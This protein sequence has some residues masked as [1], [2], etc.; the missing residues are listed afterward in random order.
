MLR[1]IFFQ[2]M[3]TTIALTPVAN[4]RGPER[5]F[6]MEGIADSF[7]TQSMLVNPAGLSLDRRTWLDYFRV[8]EHDTLHGN[9]LLFKTKG[10]GI[11]F[12]DYETGHIWTVAIG[13]SLIRSLNIDAGVNYQRLSPTDRS[14]FNLWNAGMLWRALPYASFGATVYNFNA[15]NSSGYRPEWRSGAALRTKNGRFTLSSDAVYRSEQDDLVF[16]QQARIY[17]TPAVSVQGGIGHDGLWQAGLQFDLGAYRA[18]V[19]Q[20]RDESDDDLRTIH[21]GF[22]SDLIQG[23][24]PGYG[25]QV[26]HLLIDGPIVAATRGS[27][28][29]L[30]PAKIS[31]L[32]LIDQIDQAAVD[33]VVD[34]LLLDIRFPAIDLGSVEELGQALDRFKATGKPVIA[35]IESTSLS[36]YLLAAQADHL[37]L[38]PEGTVDIAGL[39]AEILFVKGLLDKI[40]IELDLVRH[41]DYKTAME[42]Y[43]RRTL[44]PAME[45]SLQA[46]L[47]DLYARIV[48]LISTGRGISPDQVK[49]LIDGGLYHADDAL[50]QHLID[51]LVDSAQLDAY[52]EKT[53]FKKNVYLD[54][55][56]RDRNPFL[57]R[58]RVAWVTIQG[59]I[60]DGAGT[61]VVPKDVAA[62]PPIALLIRRAA[63]DPKIRAI[64]IYLNTP[65]GS[66]TASETI[67]QAIVAARRKKPV[68][69]LMGTVA[70]SG[71][72]WIASSTERIIAYPSTLTG[73]IGVF[74]VHPSF[75]EL[76]DK[77][78]LTTAQRVRGQLA[79]Y[80][81]ITRPW[82]A[83]QRQMMQKLIDRYYDSFIDHVV[84]GRSMGRPTVERV[85]QGRVWSGKRAFELGLVD[86]IGGYGEALQWLRQRIHLSPNRPIEWVPYTLESPSLFTL[87]RNGQTDATPGAAAVHNLL[88]W[89]EIPDWFTLFRR[90]EVLALL[91]ISVL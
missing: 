10:L 64:V 17:L 6:L 88:S 33:P 67:R 45:E 68:L 5:G 36:G 26:A 83:K 82:S 8:D 40:G 42:P 24:R 22:N 77:L 76:M 39:S 60:T 14:N 46:L 66:V 18:G 12:R 78:E 31:R 65:G 15:P 85:A 7:S 52:L 41:G 62:A 21:V 72:Y 32:K 47:D 71:G 20:G 55:Q 30:G 53:V 81:S 48:E 54:W 51:G 49:E 44:S 79:D 4:A 38:A 70:A 63:D 35:W 29:A 74:S 84:T 89:L 23:N 69:A 87:L 25:A 37:L 75:R 91:P 13:F 19:F 2:S 11:G 86:G 43:T 1:R 9:S 59:P 56:P 73:S 57:T 90:G 58:P 3:I 16:D 34:G 28:L 27:W 50:S 61:R 80:R